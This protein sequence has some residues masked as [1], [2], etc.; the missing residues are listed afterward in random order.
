MSIYLKIEKDYFYFITDSEIKLE[1]KIS[2]EDY[3]KF[4]SLQEQGKQF[5]IKETPAGSGLFDLI[6]ES[7][8]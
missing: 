5:K 1:N 8:L 6:E 2:E 3:F 7:N 4:I